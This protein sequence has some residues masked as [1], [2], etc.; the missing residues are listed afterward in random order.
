M[1]QR[2]GPFAD[3]FTIG[4]ISARAANNCSKWVR[5]P[6][7]GQPRKFKGVSQKRLSFSP[8][9]AMLDDCEYGF[10]IPIHGIARTTCLKVV[11][12]I[13]DLFKPSSNPS[14]RSAA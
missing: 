9:F 1:P 5:I 8:H 10:Q 3:C 2:S 14:A 4:K 7:E 6:V 13:T 11:P 12:P